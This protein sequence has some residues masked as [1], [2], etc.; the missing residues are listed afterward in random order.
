MHQAA[1]GRSTRITVP[2]I[3]AAHSAA[4]RVAFL[5]NIRYLMIVLVVIYHSVAAYATVAPHF[6][7]HDTTFVAADIIRELLD[8]FMMPVLF[9]VAGYFALASLEKKGVGEFLKDKGKR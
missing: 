3:A 5:D 4:T 9:F 2:P 8:V 1:T 6:P 7:Y